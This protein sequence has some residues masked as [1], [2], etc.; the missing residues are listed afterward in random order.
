MN[1]V[2]LLAL[3]APLNGFAQAPATPAGGDEKAAVLA[4][5]QAF[6][7]TMTSKDAAGAGRVLVAEGR[8]FSVREQDGQSVVRSRVNQEYLDGLAQQKQRYVERAWD[9]DVRIHGP[10]A[11][12]W[13][14]YDFWIDGTFSHCGVDLFNLVKTNDGWK[15]SGGVYTVERTGCPPSPLGP[16]KE[17]E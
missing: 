4:A 2:L 8:L 6:F 16:L 15:I 13:T 1:L 5:V 7:D 14:A 10:I 12:V 17:R 11:V 3:I 9:A